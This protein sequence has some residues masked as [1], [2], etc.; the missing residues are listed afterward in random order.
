M[1]KGFMNMELVQDVGVPGS[2]GEEVR[3]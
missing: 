3:V 1:Q 2:R